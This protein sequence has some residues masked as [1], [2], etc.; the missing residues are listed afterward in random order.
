M[1]VASREKLEW[2]GRKG[3]PDSKLQADRN[4]GEGMKRLQLMGMPS[5]Q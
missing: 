2:K 3:G 4:G 1:E 5:P